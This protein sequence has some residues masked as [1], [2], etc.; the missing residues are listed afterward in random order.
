VLRPAL[1]QIMDLKHPLM[2]LGDRIDWDFLD[3]RFSHGV[4][5]RT[6]PAGPA[7]PSN[8]VTWMRA[9]AAT[10]IR[11]GSGSRPGCVAPRPSSSAR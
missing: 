11:T 8:A 6:W 1:D 7:D 10:I 5:I 3:S 4:C 9:I 2:L